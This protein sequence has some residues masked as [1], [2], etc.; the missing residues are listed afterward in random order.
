MDLQRITSRH[1]FRTSENRIYRYIVYIYSCHHC[2]YNNIRTRI[3]ITHTYTDTANAVVFL[4][5]RHRLLQYCKWRIC[6]WPD[7]ETP[8]TERRPRVKYAKDYNFLF[9]PFVIISIPHPVRRVY[10]E[11]SL[12]RLRCSDIF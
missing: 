12:L 6:I 10:R 8:A 1:G 9:F 11:N 7:A 2:H 5:D 4:V 3:W